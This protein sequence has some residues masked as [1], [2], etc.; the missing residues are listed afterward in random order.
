MD[1]KG[2]S[3]MMDQISSKAKAIDRACIAI[4]QIAEYFTRSYTQMVEKTGITHSQFILL[5]LIEQSGAISLK[6][7]ASL[8]PKHVATVGQIVDRM[9]KAGWIFRLQDSRDRRRI[10]L[11]STQKGREVLK[12]APPEPAEQ[13]A[14]VMERLA[15]EE[16]DAIANMLD[17][18]K[19]LLNI[20][21][22]IDVDEHESAPVHPASENSSQPEADEM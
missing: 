19:E 7:L 18:L 11:R 6:E 5:R 17:K 8:T 22:V 13:L 14:K 20:E 4:D 21:P 9:V 15:E 10:V 12:N 1:E 2:T 3:G 16:A